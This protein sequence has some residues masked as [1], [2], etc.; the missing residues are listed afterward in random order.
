[1]IR[2]FC[3]DCISITGSCHLCPRSTY[4]R[5]PTPP[6]RPPRSNKCDLDLIVHNVPLAYDFIVFAPVGLGEGEGGEDQGA[7]RN[8]ME[9]LSFYCLAIPEGVK[10]HHQRLEFVYYVIILGVPGERKI[11]PVPHH[12]FLYSAPAERG[13]LLTSFTPYS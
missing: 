7:R 12:G 1:M 13:G 11:F 3:M 4:S 6:Y 8:V 10:T 2:T 5:V 9:V